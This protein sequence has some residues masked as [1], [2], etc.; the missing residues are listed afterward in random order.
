MY[1]FEMLLPEDIEKVLNKNNT[2]LIDLR[3][4]EDFK[5]GHIKN[6]KNLPIDYIDEWKKEIPDNLQLI[7]YCEH[8]NQSLIA[9][10]KLRGRRGKIYTVIGGYQ[11]YKKSKKI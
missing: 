5:Q 4:E 7:L 2:V 8:G 10:K 9:A 1:G 6:A 3:G 11:A